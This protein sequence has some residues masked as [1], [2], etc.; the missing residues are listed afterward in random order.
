VTRFFGVTTV[1]DCC[2]YDDVDLE[3]LRW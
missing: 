3:S 1:P 2:V